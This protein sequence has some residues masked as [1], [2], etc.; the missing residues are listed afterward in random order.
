MD[1]NFERMLSISTKMFAQISEGDKYYRAWLGLLFLLAS[2]ETNHINLSPR[3]MKAEIG[4][5]WKEDLTFLSDEHL[6][7]YKPVFDEILLSW[8]LGNLSCVNIKC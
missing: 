7:N 4:E 3:Q 5:Q 6:I 1:G 2:N 8:Y